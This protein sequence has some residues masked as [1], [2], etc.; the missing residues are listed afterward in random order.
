MKHQHTNWTAR[1]ATMQNAKV[2][3]LRHQLQDN[4]QAMIGLH[5]IWQLV[6]GIS[7]KCM[8]ASQEQSESLRWTSTQRF[9]I[10]I[11]PTVGSNQYVLFCYEL[12][13][14][15]TASC[16]TLSTH[17]KVVWYCFT[18]IFYQ[19]FPQR[20]LLKCMNYKIP[21]CCIAMLTVDTLLS[22]YF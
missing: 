14:S 17:T 4:N 10:E 5:R 12:D 21:L 16:A 3:S 8:C 18:I 11:S 9:K 22:K 19:G 15:C 1:N 7:A 6:I 13:C 20:V 2:L